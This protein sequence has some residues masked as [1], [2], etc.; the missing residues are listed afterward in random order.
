MTE[1]IVCTTCRPAGNPREQ[2]AAGDLLYEAV[3]AEQAFGE[4]PEWAHIQVRG[5][6]CTA[7]CSRACTVAFQAPGKHSYQFGDLAPA[8][9]VAR[10]LLDCAVLHHRA[11][12]GNLARDARPPLLRNGILCRLPPNLT[13]G[14]EHP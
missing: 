13:T 4:Q 8:A 3:Q 2:R 12:D 14:S 9:D 5:V 7:G 10:Q 1:L 6:A 11:P